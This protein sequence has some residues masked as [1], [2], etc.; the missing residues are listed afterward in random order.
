VT[1]TRASAELITAE[2]REAIEA[3]VYRT[4]MALPSKSALRKQHG[5]SNDVAQ[6]VFN[7]LLAEGLIVTRTGAGAFVRHPGR[8]LGVNGLFSGFPQPTRRR[9]SSPRW[10]AELL[11]LELGAEVERDDALLEERVRTA[12]RHPTKTGAPVQ[13]ETLVQARA[14]TADER[15]LLG[16]RPGTPVLVLVRIHRAS[17]GGAVVVERVTSVGAAHTLALGDSDGLQHD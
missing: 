5:C 1:T 12:W 7:N 9:E 3:G 10:I 2:L 11:E 17:D 4:G 8:A 6:S 13:V 16:L 15:S 14:G